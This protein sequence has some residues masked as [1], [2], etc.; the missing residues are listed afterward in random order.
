MLS[1]II[2]L[3]LIMI[4]GFILYAFSYSSVRKEI[5]IQNLNTFS[6]SVS[7]LEDNL[8]NISVVAG[9]ISTKSNFNKLADFTDAHSTDFA[10]LGYETQ[11]ELKSVFPLNRLIA[12]SENFIYMMNSEYIISSTIFSDFALYS[13]Y[14]LGFS[15]ENIDY[16]KRSIS[17][18]ELKNKFIHLSFFN[19]PT[20][21]YIYI[22]PISNGNT[23]S[24]NKAKAFLVCIFNKADLEALFPSL[25]YED[26]YILALNQVSL[27]SLV[28]NNGS[29]TYDLHMIETLSALD[30]KEFPLSSK[31]KN[32]DFVISLYE[33]PYYNW[34]YYLIQPFT[35]AYYPLKYYTDVFAGTGIFTLI[36]ILI[37]IYALSK[38]NAKPVQDLTNKLIDKEELASSLGSLIEKQ[39]PLIIESYIRRLM[40]GKVSSSDEVEYISNELNLHKK[41]IKYMVLYLEIY[42]SEDFDIQ[43]DDIAI[44][45]QNFDILVRDAI[46]RYFPD[47]GYLYKPSNRVF[48]VLIATPDI[49]NYEQVLRQYKEIFIQM[50][51]DL[52]ARYG[53]WSRGGLGARNESLAYIWKSYQQAKD[54]KSI[55]SSDQYILSHYDFIHSNDQYYYPD[56]IDLKLNSFISSG[57]TEQVAEIFK[58]IEKENKVNRKLT[59]AQ[60]NQLLSDIL[61]TLSKKRH[62]IEEPTDA[63]KQ[64]LLDEIDKA[65]SDEQSLMNLKNIAIKL[66]SFF[67]KANNSNDFIDKILH[68]IQENYHDPSLCLTKISDEFSISEN[69]FSYLFKREVSEN[70]SSYLEGIRMNKAKEMV[71]RSDISLSEIYQ[72]IGYNNITSFRRVFKKHFGVSPKEMRDN[73]ND[74]L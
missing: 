65:F 14:R 48:A 38:I 30:K 28:L 21:A 57:N 1:Y 42:P 70:F 32:T 34:D 56:S 67:E 24:E 71:I 62:S 9:Q 36:L 40:E 4:T 27:P 51:N 55:T 5:Y 33:S 50:H 7:R 6:A 61:S 60:T 59:Y 69:Y 19:S 3:F 26:G 63:Q 8:A 13:K 23:F 18:Q 66:C 16:F 64:K 41:G 73:K 35:Q 43:L 11:Q 53:I 68:Y 58:L 52:L 47:T 25:L 2:I 22:Y 46:K 17:S 54:A 15:Q 12:S 39:K 72:F 20:D 31:I 45:L 10:Y 44:S 49:I 37:A 29:F 74:Y